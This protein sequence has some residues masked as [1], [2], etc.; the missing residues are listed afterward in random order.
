MLFKKM[1][2]VLLCL[3]MALFCVGCKGASGG[4]NSGSSSVKEGNFDL[5]DYDLSKKIIT[6]SD[7]P[8]YPGKTSLDLYASCG[9]NT[10]PLIYWYTGY[11]P[12]TGENS[13]KFIQAIADCKEAGLDII[14][15]YGGADVDAFDFNEY[16][17]VLGFLIQDEPG[18][19]TFQ[20]L[21]DEKVTWINEKYPNLFFYVNLLPSYA[22]GSMLGTKP[23]NGKS[24][25]ENY[26][27]KYVAE[28]HGK[29]NGKKSM[30]MD[31]YPL[32]TR[33]KTNYVSD[34]YLYDLMT[35]AQAARG[36]NSDHL[37]YCIQAY[38]DRG[39]TRAIRG[40]EDILFQLYTAMA[41]GADIFEFF[42]YTSNSQYDMMVTGEGP[43]KVW[44]AVHDGLSE[45]NRFEGVYLNFAWEG[46]KSFIGTKNGEDYRASH[47]EL[48]KNKEIAL[49]GIKSVE[50]T[51]DTLIG[52]FKDK[53]G[54]QGYMVVNYTEP[55][56]GKY[57]KVSV[58]FD[59]A[60][61]VVY[62]KKGM[63]M[64][65]E[66]SNNTLDLTL[67]PGDGIFVIN[68]NK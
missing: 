19:A 54:N 60:K 51:Q 30:G 64:K 11:D 7:F 10:Y 44:N 56:D 40:S 37:S 33:Q 58:K 39:E 23:E 29:V 57:D 61:N 47:F 59:K 14:V 41:F 36:S 31:H 24:A 48:I 55:S 2:C 53:Y 9:F 46:V 1:L 25:Y 34:T 38:T 15:Q 26:V 49:S 12:A 6:F 63:E 67:A 68:Y 50:A 4:T 27:D 62:Y 13:D 32:K 3:N 16:D 17:N 43:T 35:V 65:V 42:A 5:P 28:V 45:I 8:P 52:Q 22:T 66:V 18:S 20:K 21:Y